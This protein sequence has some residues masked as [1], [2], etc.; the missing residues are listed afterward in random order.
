MHRVV[1]GASERSRLLQTTKMGRFYGVG[2]L[3]YYWRY[4]ALMVSVTGGARGALKVGQIRN[5]CHGWVMA[6]SEGLGGVYCGEEDTRGESI[7][8]FFCSIMKF[9]LK[10]GAKR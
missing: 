6:A 3:W 8:K 2:A 7:K 4:G 5:Y 1:R 10:H 9:G